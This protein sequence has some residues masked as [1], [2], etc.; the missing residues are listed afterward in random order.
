MKR[1]VK[2]KIINAL[3]SSKR[4]TINRMRTLFGYAKKLG[5]ETHWWRSSARHCYILYDEEYTMYKA[6]TFHNKIAIHTGEY[7]CNKFKHGKHR[8]FSGRYISF[9]SPGKLCTTFYVY[10]RTSKKCYAF[11]GLQAYDFIGAIISH[12]IPSNN[13]DD[14]RDAGLSSYFE[15]HDDIYDEYPMSLKFDYNTVRSACNHIVLTGM[16]SELI[17]ITK[18]CSYEFNKE[19]A[20]NGSTRNDQSC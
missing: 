7:P 19:D 14:W 3:K 6:K 2:K 16:K 5:Y 17:D 11:Y 15:F 10:D 8:I 12:E 13:F 1:R 20:I 4:V 9:I 18:K